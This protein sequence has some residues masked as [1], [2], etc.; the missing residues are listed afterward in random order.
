MRATRRAR[1][2]PR[3]TPAS[4]TA[5]VTHST[6]MKPEMTKNMSTPAMNGNRRDASN[7]WPVREAS[8]SASC[9]A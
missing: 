8:D 5:A 4:R 7:V 6:M 1:N 3:A 2:R 9:W